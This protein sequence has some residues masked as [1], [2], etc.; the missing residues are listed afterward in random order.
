VAWQILASKIPNPDP[1]FTCDG[2]SSALPGKGLKFNL[3][4]L[5]WLVNVH[6]V[7]TRM[8]NSTILQSLKAGIGD[9]EE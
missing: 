3:H 2:R 9:A 5:A 4:P 8:G 6:A 7:N 1:L